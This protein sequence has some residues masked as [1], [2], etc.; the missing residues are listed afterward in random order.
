MG[1]GVRYMQETRGFVFF[2]LSI[3]SAGRL[4]EFYGLRE[5]PLVA[6]LSEAEA[7]PN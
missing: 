3:G 2:A 5:T 4:R 7:V 1:K 6:I